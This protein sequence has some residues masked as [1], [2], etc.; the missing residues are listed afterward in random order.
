MFEHYYVYTNLDQEN[1]E[2]FRFEDEAMRAAD[3]LVATLLSQYTQ[4]S[5]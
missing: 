5:D 4:G 2:R 1:H 3:A